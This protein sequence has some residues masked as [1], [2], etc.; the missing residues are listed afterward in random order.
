MLVDIPIDELWKYK[1]SHNKE[2][3]FKNFWEETLL[4]LKHEPLEEEVVKI[5]HYV[6][7]INVNKVFYNGFG[8][9]RI[10]GFYLTPKTAN[11]SPA[12]IWFPGYGDNM[13]EVSFYLSWVLL[14]YA[15]LSLDIRGQMGESLDNKAYPGPSAVGY[16]TKGVF[17]KKDY[18]YRGVYADCIKA[19]DFLQ[20][21][22][23]IDMSRVCV[24]GASQGG[25]IALA[26]SALDNRP[27]LTIAEIPYLCHFR[28]A[29]EWAEEFKP[30]T[31][32]E[33]T[34][35]IKR[36]PHLVG[37]MYETLSY[38]D[39]LN[40][41]NLIK[42]KTILSVAMKDI[43]CPPSTV[44]AIYNNILA[45]KEIDILE[46]WDHSWE[47]VL[48]YEEKRLEHIVKNL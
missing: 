44:F 41:C 26:V 6:K 30:L 42:N 10:C 17:D 1:P 29:I 33:F 15:V 43:V 19:L 16:M 39:N 9:A 3:D 14:G 8:R 21:R 35:I 32:L 23:E 18:Y 36:F 28:R 31:Y 27:K 34:Q 45:E 37:K 13:R 46:Y 47:T 11:P 7:S 22:D 25:G 40:L 2:N 48:K 4:D 38:F 5:D 20:T 12:I 24:A